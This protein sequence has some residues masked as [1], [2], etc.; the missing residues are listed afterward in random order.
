MKVMKLLKLPA[1]SAE[2]ESS[3]QQRSFANTAQPARAFNA[4]EHLRLK[5][6]AP[7]RPSVNA[8]EQRDAD[9]DHVIVLR[10]Q[11]AGNPSVKTMLGDLEKCGHLN[12]RQVQIIESFRALGHR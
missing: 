4:S 6:V 9:L 7:P 12:G 10:S 2:N 1:R 8:L 3:L 11:L 5:I